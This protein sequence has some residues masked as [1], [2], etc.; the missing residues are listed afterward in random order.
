MM[1]FNIGAINY[2]VLSNYTDSCVANQRRLFVTLSLL[3]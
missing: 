3:S 1:L 2:L